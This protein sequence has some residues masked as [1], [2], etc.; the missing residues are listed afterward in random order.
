MIE[1]VHYFRYLSLI[2]SRK[3]INGVL[4][5]NGNKVGCL[6]GLSFELCSMNEQ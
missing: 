5:D 4:F 2:E 1:S 3:E 6:Y